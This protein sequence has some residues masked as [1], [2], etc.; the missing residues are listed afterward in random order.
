MVGAAVFITEHRQ[1]QAPGRAV[2][3]GA[4]RVAL[5]RCLLRLGRQCSGQEL[6]FTLRGLVVSAQPFMRV[7][8]IAQRMAAG[9][10]CGSD[11]CH[12]RVSNTHESV[13]LTS[14][15]GGIQRQWLQAHAR[16]M[17][18]VDAPHEKAAQ[19]KT[20]AANTRCRNRVGDR[21]WPPG[22]WLYAWVST[23]QTPQEGDHGNED[24]RT[25][26][27][28]PAAGDWR[29]I[30]RAWQHGSTT[31]SRTHGH[32]AQGVCGPLQLQSAS[33]RWNACHRLCEGTGHRRQCSHATA[34]LNLTAGRHASS[35]SIA[36]LLGGAVDGV[37]VAQITRKNFRVVQLDPRGNPTRSPVV[38]TLHPALH[39]G[40]FQS[41]SKASRSAQS[42]D[43][44][45]VGHDA[46][47]TTFKPCV[48]MACCV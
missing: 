15:V 16:H 2:G 8:R 11:V 5:A 39:W 9:A 10:V 22:P 21:G 12:G 3:T 14:T 13:P 45:A 19:A 31:G 29:T 25:D 43:Q 20:R 35:R 26:N 48:N 18:T 24:A 34:P 41:F 42:V 30:D 23:H 44:V 36:G 28:R 1:R 4:R 33:H 40:Q 17:P 46:L 27:R 47:N 37:G 7:G 32:A 6:R 38:N